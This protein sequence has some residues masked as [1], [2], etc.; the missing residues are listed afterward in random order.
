MAKKSKFNYKQILLFVLAVVA[1]VVGIYLGIELAIF[2]FPFL[3]A[4]IVYKLVKKPIEFLNKKLRFPR[5]LAAI[6]SII[7][8]IGI[9][10]SLLYVIFAMLF[11]ELSTLSQD[12]SHLLPELYTNITTLVSR[13]LYFFEQLNLSETL[14]T[15]IQTSF[16]TVTDKILTAL[17]NALNVT[18]N[19]LFDTVVSLPQI[20]IYV[21]ITVLAT[22]FICSDSDYIRES[23]EN[24]VPERWM[25]KLYNIINGL[26]KSLGGYLK[27]QGIMISIT[28][29]ELFIFFSVYG[30]KYSLILAIT[31]AIIDALPILGT[32][33]VL[34]PWSIF[35][36]ALGNYKLAIFLIILYFFVLVV[37]QLIEPRV[38]ASQIGVYPLLTL[39]A[40]YTG[41]KLIGLF[42]VIVGPIVLIIAKNV[43]QQFYKQGSL[44]EIFESKQSL[45]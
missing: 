24:H 30:M 36:L 16:F 1:A 5:G 18:V 12:F 26:V 9:V 45:Q 41:V 38:V 3:I 25:T 40:M 13:F 17:G 39:L 27:A 10:G 37:R 22:F 21:I 19:F 35:N 8:F 33:T 4:Y 43:F 44:K 6:F 29:L 34:I 15:N 20:L 31:I 42:G 2:Y 14:I 11:K 23:I 32:G 28:F 7:L